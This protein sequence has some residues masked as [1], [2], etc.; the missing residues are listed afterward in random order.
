MSVL[1]KE[2]AARPT[3]PPH[4]DDERELSTADNGAATAA[5]RRRSRKP[6]VLAAV[7]LILL[8]AAAAGVIYWLHA[9]NFEST[10]DAFVEGHVIAISPQVPARVKRVPV[11]DN[12]YVNKGD[13]L[14]ELDST[15]YD[16]AVEQARASEA[17][18]HGRLD[19]SKTQVDGARANL[20][21]GQA[22]VSVAEA[23]FANAEADYARYQQLQKSNPGAVSKQQMDT[24][25]WSHRSATAQL[26]QAKAKLAQ[27]QAQVT[28]A[29]AT[30]KTA[31]ADVAKAAADTK[32]AEVNQSYCR[33][34]APE[35]GRVTRKSVEGGMYV[36]TGQNLLA[37]VPDD[38]W[39]VANFKE[40]QLA[41][42]KPGQ[43][44][45]ISIDA[46]PGRTFTGK[47]D[48][49]QSGTGSRFS[50]LP[51]ENATGNFVKVVQRV[52][53]KIALDPGQAND[54]DHPL[55]PGMSA[56]PEVNV[57]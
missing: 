23:A 9:R 53:V 34:T 14:V 15:D 31:E 48:S 47:I 7:A 40:T 44:V 8:A 49:I 51:A 20:Q 30:V 11:S 2:P 28:T 10:D 56:E 39:I 3:A 37:L 54:R 32:H 55:A 46:W 24:S 33:I 13:V 21:E 50:M 5:R 43:P 45:T 38:V 17:A 35:S 12:Q 36:Q 57:R 42:I 18:S 4:L 19:E 22:E 26:A 29:E 16:V 6:F 27:A 1:E 52:P 41:R 25:E